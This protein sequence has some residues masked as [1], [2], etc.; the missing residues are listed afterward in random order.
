MPRA[1][2]V[3]LDRDDLRLFG[4]AIRGQFRPIG[5]VLFKVTQGDNGLLELLQLVFNRGDRLRIGCMFS[6]RQAT[7]K[8]RHLVSACF[9]IALQHKSS[10]SILS[11]LKS[12]ARG[13]RNFPRSA[14]HAFSFPRWTRR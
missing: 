2:F 10:Y 1:A 12:S 14:R 8:T 6:L 11:S 13:I 4:R 9:T 5:Y 3:S 7:R